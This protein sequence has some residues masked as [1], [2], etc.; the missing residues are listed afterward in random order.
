MGYD[1][2]CALGDHD[3]KVD[4]VD[5]IEKGSDVIIT[6]RFRFKDGEIGSKDLYPLKSEKSAQ[7][8]RKAMS[9]MGFDM[10]TRDLG[11]LQKNP[12]L[13]KGNDVRLVVQEHEWNG[14]VTNQ[15]AFVNAIPKPASRSLLDKANAAL[16][17]AKKNDP[18]EGL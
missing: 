11:E 5:L 15:I 17:A 14:N 2:S 7:M 4:T 13:L 16:K 9:A 12:S 6:C 1:V 10:N 3:A 8:S 18:N